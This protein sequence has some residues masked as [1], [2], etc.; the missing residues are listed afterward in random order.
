VARLHHSLASWTV[1]HL[2]HTTGKISGD[3]AATGPAPQPAGDP[4]LG[5]TPRERRVVWG[6]GLLF[7]AWAL[8]L[9]R[10]VYDLRELLPAWGWTLFAYLCLASAAFEPWYVLWVVA[11]AALAPRTLLARSTLFL[12]VTVL[13]IIAGPVWVARFGHEPVDLPLYVLLPPLAYAA[14][15]YIRRRRVAV[16]AAQFVPAQLR[17]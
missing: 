4:A 17:K 2:A 14:L 12:S 3:A 6:F 1:L 8:L 9:L 7:A 11:L 16:P 13:L 5:L 10:R 15:G